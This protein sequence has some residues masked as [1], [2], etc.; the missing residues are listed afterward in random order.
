MH[1]SADRRNVTRTLLRTLSRSDLGG[2]VLVPEGDP[3]GPDATTARWV[4]VTVTD[5][6]A[7]YAGRDSSGN[8]LAMTRLIVTVDVFQRDASTAAVGSVDEVDGIASRVRD[9]L[10]FVDLPLLDLVLDPS[11]A[12]PVTGYALRSMG[13]PRVTTPPTIDGYQRRQVSCDLLWLARTE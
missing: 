13:A 2:A 12:T 5:G 4:R 1:A 3:R 7:D 6:R 11:G 10:A 9:A 8:R